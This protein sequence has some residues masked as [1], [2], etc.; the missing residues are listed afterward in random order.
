MNESCETEC[1]TLMFYLEK[2]SRE[3]EKNLNEY[4]DEST[5]DLTLDIM[6]TCYKMIQAM[7]VDH[8]EFRSEFRGDFRSLAR[9]IEKL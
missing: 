5:V 4:I 8:P 1:Q 9:M 2:S 3:L 7:E 6:H